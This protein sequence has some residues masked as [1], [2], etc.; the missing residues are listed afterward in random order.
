MNEDAFVIATRNQSTMKEVLHSLK[1]LKAGAR[2]HVYFDPKQVRAAIVTCGGLCPGL[3]VVI[4]E[5]V[6]SLYYNY[7]A[8][9]IWGVKWG[10]KGFYS[11]DD[12]WMRLDPKVVKNI[13]KQGGTILGSSRG[14]F[15]GEKI[16]A[17][18]SER[19]IN[20][21]YVIGG[22][23]T[24]RGVNALIQKAIEKK[25]MISFVGIPKTID[26]D[27]PLI[28]S[29]FGFNTSCEV[30][31]R[32]IEA[33]Y[34]EATNAQN[35]VGL[36]KL[37]GRYSG[38]IAR[39]AALSNGNVDICL[40]PELSFELGGEKGLYETILARVRQQG[41]CVVVVAEGAE[42]GLINPHEHI[43]K[44]PRRDDS[45]NVIF[46]DIGKFL[47]EEIVKYAKEQHKM[48]LTLKYIDPTY[49]IRSVNSNAVDTIM[50]AKLA[51]NAVHGAMFGYTGFSVGIVRNSVCW[52]PVTTLIKAGTNRMSMTDRIWQR[53]MSQSSQRDMVNPEF[54]EEAKKLVI[55][56]A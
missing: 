34:V 56:R 10:Y 8:K 32:M 16:L 22:D 27:I 45:N 37:M 35:G 5:I 11:G 18:L 33:A 19:G 29:S 48:S 3:N 30:A 43:T 36:I 51:Q 21:V 23:G 24:H 2:E 14:G 54:E 31:A 6:M 46:D 55:Q 7:E 38:F 41:H 47:K 1:F 50:C 52:I 26:N 17:A 39:N 13:H 53:L 28:D 20:Q 40:V 15:D 49:A 4:R 9:E 42:E 12:N 44:N 25:L